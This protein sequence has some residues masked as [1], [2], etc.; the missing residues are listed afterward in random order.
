MF[1]FLR[2]ILTSLAAISLV[3][4]ACGGEEASV[5]EGSSLVVVTTNI[6]GDVVEELVGDQLVVETIMPSGADPHVFQA[7]AKQV[8]QMT[9]ADV[10]VVNGA[11]FEEGLLDVISSVESD[12]VAVFEAMS[13]VRAKE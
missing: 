1:K 2:S 6:L 10:L 11:S 7:S 5:A 12:G 13:V 4:T 8:D 3:L 9:K